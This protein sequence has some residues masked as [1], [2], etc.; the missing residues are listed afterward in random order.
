MAFGHIWQ[1]SFFLSC[2]QHLHVSISLYVSNP[3]YA[4]SNPSSNFNSISSQA[5]IIYLNK[6]ASSVYC[7]G[8]KKIKIFYSILIFA[9]AATKSLSGFATGRERGG[10]LEV[11]MNLMPPGVTNISFFSILWAFRAASS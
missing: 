11:H 2:I 4:G 8:L 1:P 9:V 6:F 3:L 7:Y 5:G 10:W